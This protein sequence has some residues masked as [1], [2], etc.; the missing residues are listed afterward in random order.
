[1]VNISAA[2]ANAMAENTA[3]VLPE[4]CEKMPEHTSQP[5]PLA[6]AQRLQIPEP[7]PLPP[8]PETRTL[9]GLQ[10]LGLVTPQKPRPVAH[11]P[12]ELEET[13]NTPAVNVE[14]QQ[15]GESAGGN[16]LPDGP[17]PYVPLVDVTL[18]DVALQYFPLMDLPLM[19]VPLPDVPLPDVPLLDVPLTDVRL[20]NVPFPDVSLPDVPLPDVLLPDVPFMDVPLPDGHVPDVSQ[21]EARLDSAVREV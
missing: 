9:S 17:L 2:D 18:R 5:Y 3:T 6:P 14:Q 1:M 21:A 7:H 8:T 15:L 16:G 4:R 11:T 19:D 12:P 20:T 10:L 13:R